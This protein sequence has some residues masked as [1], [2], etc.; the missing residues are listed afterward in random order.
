MPECVD[1]SPRVAVPRGGEKPFVPMGCLSNDS[2]LITDIESRAGNS[3]AKFQNG[4]TLFARIT[5]CLEN[6]K[7]GF[8]Q[9]LPDAQAVGFGSTEFIVLRSR[10]LTSEFVYLLARSDEFRGVAIKSMSG[11]TGRQRVQ[12]RCFDDFQIAQSSYVLRALLPAVILSSLEPDLKL[13]ARQDVLGELDIKRAEVVQKWQA[14][15]KNNPDL[16]YEVRPEGD[17]LPKVRVSRETDYRV[18]EIVPWVA[19]EKYLFGQV[20]DMGGAQKA[21]VHLKLD[22]GGK[23]LLV[24]AS[25]GYL[26]E[27]VENRLYHKALLYVRAEQHFR[28]GDLRN[29]QLISFVDYEPAYNEEALD[30]FTAKGAE[31]WADVPDAAQWVREVRGG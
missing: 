6:G 13:L 11:A 23:T 5:P 28:T 18:G 29:I 30:R 19:V 4:D 1:I 31:A 2:M 26:R 7:T 3:G 20:V 24:G 25:Q 10:T 27:Q 21:N 12:E 17:A 15:A 14:R 9:F 16:S 22:R 8:V